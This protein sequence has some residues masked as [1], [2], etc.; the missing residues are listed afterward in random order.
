LAKA[1]DQFRATDIT[2]WGVVALACCG[3]AVLSA[4]VS[5]ALPP[6][7]L[8]GLHASR[9]E[10]GGVAQLRARVAELEAQTDR[11]GREKEALLLRFNLAEEASGEVTRRVGALEGSIPSLLEELTAR[12]VNTAALTASPAPAASNAP[13]DTTIVTSSIDGYEVFETEGGTVSVRRV[14][15][16]PLPAPE[17]IEQEIPVVI[18]EAEEAETPILGV[19]GI[20]IGPSVAVDT[21]GADWERL[22]AKVGT[23]LLGLEPLLSEDVDPERRRIVAGPVE[24]IP[25]AEALCRRMALVNIACL[26]VPY[27]GEPLSN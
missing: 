18:A 17:A 20:A 14:P 6:G 12:D 22:N 5:A 1:A 8:A 24:D 19:Y 16:T 21:A 25:A 23:L 13:V 10:G 7:L 26:P 9:I 4:N 15:M 11:L 27:S 3:L 2:F